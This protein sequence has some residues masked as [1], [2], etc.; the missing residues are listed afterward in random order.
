MCD[1]V[2]V[3][4]IECRWYL[5]MCDMTVFDFYLKKLSANRTNDFKM[6]LVDSKVTDPHCWST[7]P[8]FTQQNKIMM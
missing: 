6:L 7:L 4:N 2:A 1:R 3:D 5:G 8:S